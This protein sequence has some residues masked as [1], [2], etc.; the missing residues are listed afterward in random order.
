[1]N[2]IRELTK[3]SNGK[4][5]DIEFPITLFNKDGHIVYYE[6]EDRYWQKREYKKEGD[7]MYLEDSLG[8]WSKCKYKDGKQVYYEDSDGLWWTREYE[9]DKE[10]YFENSDGDIIDYREPV[11]MT[12][13]EIIKELGK[14]IRIIE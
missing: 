1:M 3:L 11:D 14:N 12:M 13:E 8:F 9:G 2:T 7:Q 5:L 6:Y 4:E 10:I